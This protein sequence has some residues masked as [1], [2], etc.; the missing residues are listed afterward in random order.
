MTETV[1]RRLIAE[2]AP[3][4]EISE[5]LGLRG[6]RSL[7]QN[8]RR[9]NEIATHLH[10]ALVFTDLDRP[11][12]CPPALLREWTQGLTMS[13]RLMIRV[14]VLEIEAWLLAD[15]AGLAQW[16]SIAVNRVP[17]NPEHVPD[18]KRALVELAGRSRNHELREAIVPRHGTGTHR[19][20]PGYNRSVGEF[21]AQYWNPEIARL[22]APSLDRSIARINELAASLAR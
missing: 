6:S 20:G 11:Q 21:V 18:P 15:R 3:D 13:S 7:R 8:L 2:Y 14:A 22:N 19:T 1:S 17:P 4:V 16:L 9:L 10:P 12:S 5:T